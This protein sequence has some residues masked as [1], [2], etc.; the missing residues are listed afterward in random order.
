MMLS[1]ALLDSNVGTVLPSRTGFILMPSLHCGGR[2]GTGSLWVSG[3]TLGAGSD[4]VG[5]GY[6]PIYSTVLVLVA[7]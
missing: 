3:S 1:T 2:N 5:L 6:M 7:S 4:H